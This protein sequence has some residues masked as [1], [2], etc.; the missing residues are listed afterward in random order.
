M[1]VV[2]F[3]GL[4]LF[5]QD[6]HLLHDF[7]DFFCGS[8]IGSGNSRTV[9]VYAPD[10]TYVLKINRKEDGK[11]AF[12]NIN[13]WDT[14]HNVMHKSPQLG[15]FLCPVAQISGCGRIL[16]MKKTTPIKDKQK[17]PKQ[18]PAFLADTKIQN[19][20]RLPNGKIVCHDYANS[21]I[22]S[23]MTTKLITPEWWSDSYQDKMKLK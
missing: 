1:A 9:Y 16:M 13:E 2:S 8:W 11:T 14:Y 7:F 12:E 4:E 15:K 18:I 3:D 20:G 23:K 21:H 10:P 6:F 17:M 5:K 19:W 22:Y